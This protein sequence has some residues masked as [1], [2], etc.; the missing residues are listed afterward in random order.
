M[1][2]IGSTFALA[3]F[4]LCTFRAGAQQNW[5]SQLGPAALEARQTHAGVDVVTLGD[6]MQRVYIFLPAGPSIQ[7]PAPFVFFHHGWQGMNPKNYGALID[8][9]AREG[10]VVVF[11]VYQDADSTSPQI[12]VDNAAQAE[13][14]ALVELKQ[15]GIVPDPQRV[16]DF[17]YSIGAAIS[18][19]LAATTASTHLPAPQALVLAAPGD[20]YHVAKGEEAK[21]I[22]PVLQDLPATLPIAIVTGEDDKYIGLPTGRKL[23][24]LICATKPDRRVLLVMPSDEHEGKKVNAGHASPGS[25]DTR[26]DIDLATPLAKAPT[27]IAGHKGFE[28]SASL[29]QLDFFGYWKV[30]DAVIDSLVASPSTSSQYVPPAIV[31]Q[32]GTP[33]QLYLGTWPDGTL[34]RQAHVEDPCASR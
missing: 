11:P 10:N 15:R 20:S 28:E 21:S 31:F 25:P 1:K 22:W 33:G 14:E 17:G 30:L 29:N 18:L 8:H 5:Q 19:K 34:Y 23:A 3:A 9:L 27:Q 12:V 6:G 13:R 2:R 26:Y 4:A 24:G 7:G 16:V 32:S